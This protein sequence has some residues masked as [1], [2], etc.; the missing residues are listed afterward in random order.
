MPTKW[1]GFDMDECIGSVMSLYTF[2]VTLPRLGVPRRA[3]HD[4]VKQSL[5]LSE[6]AQETWLF[7]PAMYGALDRVYKAYKAG[8]IAGTFVFSNNGSADLVQF[9]ADY[10]NYVMSRKHRDFS[11]P[12]IFQMAV[13][14]GSPLRSPGSLEK[15]YAEIVRALGGAGLPLPSGPQ[16]LLFFDDL[17]H[18]LQSEIPHYVQVRAYM[19]ACPLDRVIAALEPCEEI[20]TPEIWGQALTMARG[21]DRS[22]RREGALSI[23]PTVKDTRS[24]AEVFETAFDRFLSVTGGGGTRRR[25]RFCRH[26]RRLHRR[27]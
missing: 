13:C 15:S 4:C 14:R 12:R 23:P 19:N 20:V 3:L 16:D 8:Q 18:T 6:R 1:V 27:K 24:D 21:D 9:V 2:V 11:K 25:R 5:Y 22:E 7:R 10:C 17:P 26:T